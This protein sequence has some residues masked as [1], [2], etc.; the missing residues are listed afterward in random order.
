MKI[1]SLPVHEIVETLGARCTPSLP[2]ENVSVERIVTDS[3]SAGQGQGRMFVALVT[4]KGNG[5]EYIRPMYQ[6]GVRF[7]LVSENRPEYDSMPDAFFIQVPDTLAA[8]Q[9]LAAESL[10]SIIYKRPSL[11]IRDCHNMTS[12]ANTKSISISTI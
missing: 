12:I 4:R 8:L 9:R 2:A 6:S 5:H 3:R 7:F 11:A 10:Y 1:A